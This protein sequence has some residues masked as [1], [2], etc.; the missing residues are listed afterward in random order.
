MVFYR[1]NAYLYFPNYTMTVSVKR[2]SDIQYSSPDLEVDG[3]FLKGNCVTPRVFPNTTRLRERSK[4]EIIERYSG[5]ITKGEF[6]VTNLYQSR[7]EE[8]TKCLGQV[9]EGKF[10]FDSIP[11]N[12]NVQI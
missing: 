2:N 12:W 9:F 6:V 5:S 1:I 4:M 11:D 10:Y 3:L 7:W 8:V